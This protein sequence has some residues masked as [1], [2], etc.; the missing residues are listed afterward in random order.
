M[1]SPAIPMLCTT[2]RSSPGV[3]SNALAEDA[4]GHADTLLQVEQSSVLGYLH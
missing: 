4:I 1:H 2:L 3:G